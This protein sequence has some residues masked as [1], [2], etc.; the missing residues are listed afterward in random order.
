M[1]FL[2]LTVLKRSIS[3]IICKILLKRKIKNQKQ[4][5]FSNKKSNH[6][7]GVCSVSRMHGIGRR[8]RLHFK[9][10]VEFLTLSCFRF[11]SFSDKTHSDRYYNG[12]SKTKT[13]NRE[14]NSTEWIVGIH[15]IC[16]SA[17]SNCWVERL[18]CDHKT[19]TG[20]ITGPK[21]IILQGRI[22]VWNPTI[23]M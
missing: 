14:N 16:R 23:D 17:D 13:E 5:T 22:M 4:K 10:L 21:S 20:I 12:Q 19:G 3:R 7:Y 6:S 9:G 18:P 15:S 8:S 1:K 11:L 2:K